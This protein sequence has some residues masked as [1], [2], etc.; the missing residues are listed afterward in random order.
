MLNNNIIVIRGYA[1]SY[2]SDL[3]QILVNTV[4]ARKCCYIDV[5]GNKDLNL[6]NILVYSD[7]IHEFNVVEEII[8]DNEVIVIDY[9]SLLKLY[10]DEV[11]LL[12]KLC[13]IA[14]NKTLIIIECVNSER[15]IM[16]DERYG[17]LKSKANLIITLDRTM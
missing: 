15:N 9:V 17:D 4:K 1:G 2:K 6:N 14:N 3:A 12:N 7:K 16:L 10:T 13:S 11:D 5:E 8:N